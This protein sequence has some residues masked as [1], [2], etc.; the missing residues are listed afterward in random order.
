MSDDSLVSRLSGS[1]ISEFNE[2]CNLTLD[3]VAPYCESPIEA[4]F[5][6]ALL[7]AVRVY[8]RGVALVHFMP[9]I[10]PSG[11][12]IVFPQYNWRNYRIDW[13]LRSAIRDID[14]FVECDGHDFHER[15]KEQAERDRSRDR[16]VTEAHIPLLRFTGREIY[17]NAGAC[18]IQAYRVF[19][20]AERR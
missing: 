15:T 19:T 5:G 4:L 16:E 18:A 2:A 3:E 11:G 7:M 8:W 13:V 14:I 1:L 20:D 6:A 17:R 10:K 12:L 9:P